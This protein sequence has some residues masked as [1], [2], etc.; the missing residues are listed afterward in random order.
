MTN[1]VLVPAAV[2]VAAAAVVVGS[3]DSTGR[4]FG[5]SNPP[6]F[7]Y[8]RLS[9]W[10]PPP[11]QP[12]FQRLQQMRLPRLWSYHLTQVKGQMLM[13]PARRHLRSREGS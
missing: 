12:Q 9:E 10:V 1:P 2:A 6:V 5:F 11:L 13:A 3:A 7:P 8:R 4:A